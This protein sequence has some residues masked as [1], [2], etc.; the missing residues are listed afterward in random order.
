MQKYFLFSSYN[1]LFFKGFVIAVTMIR[2]AIDDLRR[3]KR[4]QD[5]NQQMYH[6]LTQFGGEKS[7]TSAAIKVG[8]FITVEKVI[9]IYREKIFITNF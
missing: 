4:D 5:V 9:N 1:D 3:R 2:E 7:I 6:K 8:D